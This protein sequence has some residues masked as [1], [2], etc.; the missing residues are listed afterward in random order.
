MKKFKGVIACLVMI[1]GLI[2]MLVK[3]NSV[4]PAGNSLAE[5]ATMDS[6]TL[7]VIEK[8]T[9]G[10]RSKKTLAS[11]MKFEGSD[12]YTMHYYEDYGFKQYLEKGAPEKIEQITFG[13]SIFKAQTPTK[14]ILMGRNF[15]WFPESGLLLF[16][17]PSDGYAAVTMVDLRTLGYKGGN[18]LDLSPEKRKALLLSPYCPVDGMNECGLAV[19]CMMVP[20]AGQ[21]KDPNKVSLS[22]T[23]AIRLMLD[24]AKNVDEAIALLEKYNIKMDLVPV[25]YLVCDATGNSAVIEFVDGK[26]QVLRSGKSWQTATNFLLTT[27][28]HEGFGQDRYNIVEGFLEGKQGTVDESEAMNILSQVAQHGECST[29]WSVVYNVSSGDIQLVKDGD[30]TNVH[31]FK[32]SEY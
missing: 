20:N 28:T 2:A 30:Y 24:Y 23:T 7:Q 12:L 21:S 5:R 14:Q 17:H 32:L 15:D 10:P 25:H 6:Q 9:V 4:K 13:C 8:A 16:T 27:Q 26:M 3:E 11:L 31:N 1:L 29:L 18:L 19:G 22:T